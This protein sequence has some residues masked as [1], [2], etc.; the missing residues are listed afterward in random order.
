MDYSNFLHENWLIIS[1][2]VSGAIAGNPRTVKRL[3]GIFTLFF[4]LYR[5]FIFFR[6]LKNPAFRRFLGRIFIT[7]FLIIL[8][9]S[10]ALA[11][12][13]CA[14]APDR[15]NVTSN[16]VPSIYDESE[17]SFDK[18]RVLSQK[19]IMP[20][21]VKVLKKKFITSKKNFIMKAKIDQYFDNFATLAVDIK[22]KR[23]DISKQHK[24]QLK[25]IK[26][27]FRDERS[28][29]RKSLIVSC[30][31]RANKLRVIN[32]EI[33]KLAIDYGKNIIRVASDLGISKKRLMKLPLNTCEKYGLSF[34]FRLK[35][36]A[37]ALGSKWFFC[38]N[39]ATIG[40]IPAK[41]KY[42]MISKASMVKKLSLAYRTKYN[43]YSHCKKVSKSK[44]FNK[45]KMGLFPS[46]RLN[47]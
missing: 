22:S 45:L 12:T 44:Y 5:T 17:R 11:T 4:S 7:T 18:N 39:Y 29:V 25:I 34:F 6:E 47:E 10:F 16:L 36:K 13:G 41:N 32:K 3:L 28:A 23:K 14:K 2:F 42:D 43:D 27:E 37:K 15:S 24:K 46:R 26:K 9:L 21:Q 20:K 30:N 35:H 38:S 1:G 33:A 8:L 19:V 40:I 31:V